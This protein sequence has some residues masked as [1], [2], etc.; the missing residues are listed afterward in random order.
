V[1]ENERKNQFEA[2]LSI[3]DEFNIDDVIE[4][5]KKNYDLPE[6]LDKNNKKIYEIIKE[7]QRNKVYVN[8]ISDGRLLAAKSKF[9]SLSLEEKKESFIRNR[10][11]KKSENLNDFHHEMSQF[12]SL[13]HILQKKNIENLNFTLKNL[14]NPQ[15]KSI[16][17]PK[18]FKNP[19]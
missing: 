11:S 15:K 12:Q 8:K 13:Q 19:S 18:I 2:N 4:N 7:N 6:L 17:L 9:F 3:N 14:Q 16:I 1:I 5:N 10:S